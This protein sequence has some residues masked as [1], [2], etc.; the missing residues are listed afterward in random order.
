MP[1]A[2]ADDEF[3][4]VFLPGFPQFGGADEVAELGVAAN[5][6]FCHQFRVSGESGGHSSLTRI[7]GVRNLHYHRHERPRGLAH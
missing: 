6:F 7:L 2:L 3:Y 1:A 5:L 4:G